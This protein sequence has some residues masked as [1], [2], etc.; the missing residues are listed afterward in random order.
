[1]NCRFLNLYQIH[2]GDPEIH[3][4]IVHVL[5]V[6]DKALNVEFFHG[7]TAPEESVQCIFELKF[8]GAAVSCSLS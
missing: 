2:T 6:N 7:V 4:H 8:S 5:I 3:V 1:M